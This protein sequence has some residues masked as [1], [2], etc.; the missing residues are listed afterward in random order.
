MIKALVKN[1]QPLRGHEEFTD[2]E[3]GVSGGFIF[4]LNERPCV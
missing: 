1:G 2:I 4:E 3:D